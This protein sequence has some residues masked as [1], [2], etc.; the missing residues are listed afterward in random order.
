MAEG[1]GPV[2]SLAKALWK[3]L[4]PHYPAVDTVRLLDYKVRVVNPKAA[5]EAKVRVMIEFID[6]QT[7][8]L[9]GTVGVSENII[10]ASWQAL[11]DG[12][13]YKLLS[14]LDRQGAPSAS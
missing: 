9:F 6:E 12:V 14:D 7:H 5:T 11:V 13:E 10:D 2:D 8:E 4:R 3:A 1:D